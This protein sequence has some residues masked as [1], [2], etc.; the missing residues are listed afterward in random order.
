MTAQHCL[1]SGNWFFTE[2]DLFVYVGLD[3]LDQAS[4][5]R[6]Y[7]VSRIFK[8]EDYNDGLENDLAILELEGSVQNAAIAR[9]YLE[10]LQK[11]YR[12]EFRTLGYGKTSPIIINS[13]GEI[14]QEGTNGNELKMAFFKETNRCLP[15]KF[16]LKPY[17]D[18]Q[19][20]CCGDSVSI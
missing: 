14:I 7:R 12:G 5:R 17:D 1:N 11:P 3:R 6:P 20:V 18:S 8:H 16:C 13:D 9:L 4:S 15:K 2:N 19:N 10:E